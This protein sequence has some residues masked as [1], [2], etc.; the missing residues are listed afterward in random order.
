[1]HPI[2]R[3]ALVVWEEKIWETRWVARALLRGVS[4][5]HRLTRVHCS[6]SYNPDLDTHLRKLST[7]RKLLLVAHGEGGYFVSLPKAWWGN[8]DKSLDVYA[9]GCGSAECFAEYKLSDRVESFVGYRDDVN[10]FVGTRR[11]REVMGR[12]LGSIGKRF[13]ST[14]RL[15]PKF[16]N[17]IELD[18]VIAM[19][20]IQASYDREGGDRLS[21]I[22]LEEQLKGLE[23]LRREDVAI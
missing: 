10:F 9:L 4:L 18:Y 22:F 7:P 23:L 11:A 8:H 5:F 14:S 19:Q 2:R 6:E 12:L 21:L 20:Y 1:M 15:T 13:A 17:G 16:K 3:K